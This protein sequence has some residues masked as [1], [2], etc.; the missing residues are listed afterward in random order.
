MLGEK[1][2]KTPAGNPQKY[3]GPSDDKTPG[4][5]N[6]FS[7]FD[8]ARLLGWER[9]LEAQYAMIPQRLV[10]S[11]PHLNGEGCRLLGIRP[12]DFT[13]HGVIDPAPEDFNPRP[14][15]EPGTPTSGTWK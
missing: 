3:L 4:V 15:S 6:L 13:E 5:G 2:Y 14:N 7:A 11:L 12:T 10:T 9:P 8:N 1:T